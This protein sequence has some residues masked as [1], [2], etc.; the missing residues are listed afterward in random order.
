[1]HDIRG[2][3]KRIEET[4]FRHRLAEPGAFRKH[5]DESAGAN[6]YGIADAANILYTI[7]SFPRDRR[8]REAIVAVLADMQS[9]DDGLFHEGTHHPIHTT[10][11]CIAALELFDAS[12]SR[13]PTSLLKY[14]SVEGI[15]GFLDS[16]DWRERPWTE[17][18]RGAGV[19]V[20]LVLTGS[21]DDAWEDA[22]F[23]WLAEETDRE[24]GLHRRGALPS[25]SPATRFPNLA[26]TFHYLFNVIFA[27]RPIRYPEALIN[28]A[29]EIGRDDASPLGST[30]G[31]AE[32]DWVYCLNRARWQSGYRFSEV[33]DA[34]LRFA[35]SYIPM[36]QS[37]DHESDERW[38]DLH[39]L[40]G[41]TCALAELQQALP[42]YIRSSTPLR[43]VLDRRPFI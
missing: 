25:G 34:L 42:G 43:L 26:G 36:L 18:H 4:V 6:P 41:A 38:N 37:I 32:I 23:D 30:V 5:A 13:P 21:V 7:G 17:A 9:E 8:D 29:M 10:A 14:K 33:T 12:P 40:F 2:L 11:H 22:Y 24:T 31:F 16:L 19:Y 1:M 35:D 28:A 15:R 39:M 3:V 20:A 27:R